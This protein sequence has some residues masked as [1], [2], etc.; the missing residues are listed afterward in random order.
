MKKILVVIFLFFVQ[1]TLFSQVVKDYNPA[2]QPTKHMQYFKP[3]ESHLFAGD[4]MPFNYNGTFYLYWLLDEGNHSGLGGLGG[5]QWALST[6][7]D[8]INWKHYPVALGIDEDWEKSICTGSVIADGN[9]IYAYYS[10]RVQDE[11]G[12]HEQLS[13]AMSTDG[14]ITFRK[15]QPNPFYFAPEECVSRD[16]RDP[17]A[18][19][20]KDGVFH[21]FI[22]GYQKNPNVGGQGG[23][24]VHLVS[25][26]LKNWTETKSPLQGQGGVPECSD[27]FKWND[28]YYLLYSIGGDTYYVKSKDPYG[29][30]EYPTTQALVERWANVAKTAEFKGRR[31]AVWYMNTKKNFKDSE[32]PVW[33]G[34][35]LMRELFQQKDGTLTIGYLPEVAPAMS[36]VSVP[37]ITV[38]STPDNIA[39]VKGKTIDINT[40]D[41]ISMAVMPG[42]PKQYRITM[43][44]EPQ[45][46]YD[47]L[48]LFLKA[49]DKERKGYKL[50]LNPNKQ[51]VNL[52][53]TGIEGVGG[54]RKTIKLDVTVMNDVVDVY[55][56]NERALVNRLAEQKGEN[57][58][59]FVKNGHAIVKDI[60]LY[61]IK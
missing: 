38:P 13:Y 9:K 42:M 47:E 61:E 8:L 12:V 58:F 17:R 22:S 59:F 43:T 54:L 27:Y 19:K 40:P 3:V 39:S 36:P 26:D 2:I 52:F 30:W 23:Y 35:I 53:E 48:G 6:S 5:H 55:I 15:Q 18:F 37:A 21:L 7:D 16:F 28:W 60:K 44:I 4:C 50:S 11:K 57:L 56:N 25:K 41:G 49:T 24:L 45:G 31:I 1:L 32:G 34:S 20:D 10:T 33:G 51:R 46:N 29:P 14:G